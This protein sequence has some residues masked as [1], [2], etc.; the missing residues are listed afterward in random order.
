MP[1]F[2]TG[3]AT[4]GELNLRGLT[5]EQENVVL[6]ETVSHLQRELEKHRRAPFIVTSV[7]ELHSDDEVV[8]RLNGG[9]FYV[10][11]AEPLVGKLKPLDQVLVE[12]K[13]LTVVKKIGKSKHFDVS[14]YVIMEKPT[15]EWS[16]IGG[17]EKQAQEL[18]EVIELPLLKPQL[19]EEIGIQPAKGILL[20]GPPGTGKTL[21]A[22]A[23]AKN[24]HAT[25]IEIVGSELVQKFIGE[26]T[27][28][29]K[30]IF[31]LAREKAPAIIFIDEIDAIASKRIEV[32]TSG[33]REVQ[34]TFMQ[35]LAE[36]DGFRP[37]GNVKVIGATNRLDIL[38]PAVIRPGRLD[39]IIEVGLP[40]EKGRL[41]ILKIH[42]AKMKLAKG[43]SLE[44]IAKRTPQMSGAELRAI[45]MEA[46]YFAIREERTK[47]SKEDFELAI[48]KVK[49]IEDKP[50]LYTGNRHMYGELPIA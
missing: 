47:V 16:Q 13:S 39:R 35:L 29:V 25:F 40:D 10:Q 44:K 38:D 21:L 6:K 14:S 37:L 28:F 24:S 9:D 18:R 4:A 34:R 32:G 19:F 46:G 8:I 26:G 1:E 36:I 2:D 30:S 49:K 7:I 15:T 31:D 12:Q 43:I 33:E 27:K 48:K 3:V 20:Y 17:L 11:V 5:P 45:C 41:Q 42:S 22:K 50:E 23:A